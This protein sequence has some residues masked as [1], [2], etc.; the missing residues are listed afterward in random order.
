MRFG[1]W[2][3]VL[4]TTGS[5]IYGAGNELQANR[6]APAQTSYP[7]RPDQVFNPQGKGAIHS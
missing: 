5:L 2:L 6:L 1:L 7:V 3:P 4:I